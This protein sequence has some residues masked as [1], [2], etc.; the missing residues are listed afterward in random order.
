MRVLHKK[1]NPLL[2]NSLKNHLDFI[3]KRKENDQILQILKRK[4]VLIE[5]KKGIGKSCELSVIGSEW[6]QR[7]GLV[8]R[9]TGTGMVDG[10][11]AYSIS[12]NGMVEMPLLSCQILKNFK[13][14][15][16]LSSYPKIKNMIEHVKEENATKILIDL[17]QILEKSDKSLLIIDQVNALYSKSKYFDQESKEI[18]SHR[19]QVPNLFLNIIKSGKMKSVIAQDYSNTG[20]QAYKF[21]D[22]IQSKGGIK[23]PRQELV[24]SDEFP[25]DLLPLDLQVYKL[26]NLTKE[27]VQ[28]WIEIFSKEG[29]ISKALRKFFQ[30]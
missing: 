9:E 3:I 16:D 7:G 29:L 28:A 8:L 19:L 23:K 5:G 10:S 17:L 21:Q 4:S 24:E 22:L 26:E 13:E 6:K 1:I 20:F 27:Q 14:F 11:W 15:N 18:L 30:F 2:F 12:K 25:K